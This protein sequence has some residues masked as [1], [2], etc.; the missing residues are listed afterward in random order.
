MTKN[1]ATP[2]V[3][4]PGNTNVNDTTDPNALFCRAYF[5]TG[6]SCPMTHTWYA[7]I[8]IK[9]R[10]GIEGLPKFNGNF[11]SNDKSVVKY[12]QRSAQ[13]LLHEAANSQTNRHSKV[14]QQVK[15]NHLGQGK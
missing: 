8:F 2:S 11:L 4:V 7:N 10:T 6:L 5:Y 12:S 9:I 13:Q 14:I 1:S 3:T 15:H